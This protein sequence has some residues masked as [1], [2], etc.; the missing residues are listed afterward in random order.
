M[1]K[2][3]SKANQGLIG[4]VGRAYASQ[5]NLMTPKGVEALGSGIVELGK[6]VAKAKQK[7]EKGDTGSTLPNPKDEIKVDPKKGS[8]SLWN[9]PSKSKFD[10]NSPSGTSPLPKKSAFKY[11]ASLVNA[12]AKAYGSEGSLVTPKAL[13]GLTKPLF[14][15]INNLAKQSKDY[16]SKM[17]ALNKSKGEDYSGTNPKVLQNIVDIQ[18]ETDAVLQ[19]SKG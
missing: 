4:A 6:G 14:N 17:V 16:T 12:V 11:N 9:P 5:G 8:Q 19:E 3:L 15:T 2:K 10:I 18:A 7:V 1:A 13:G